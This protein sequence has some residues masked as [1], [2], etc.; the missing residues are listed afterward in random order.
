MWNPISRK[1]QKTSSRSA[2]RRTT[3]Q[4]EALEQRLALSTFLV[5]TAADSGSGSLRQAILDANAAAGAD[6][7]EFNIGGGGAQTISPTSALPNITESVTID[8]WTQPGFAGTPL[9]ELS[10]AVAGPGISG[11]MIAANNSSARGLVINGFGYAGIVITGHDNLVQGNYLGTNAAGTAAMGNGVYGVHIVDASHNRVEGNVISGNGPPGD[12]PG[13][14][15]V[16]VS[17]LQLTG[18][19]Q[20]NTVIGN[21]I[22]T[23]RDGS[24]PIPNV[25]GVFIGGGTRFNT[26]E[27]NLIASNAWYGVALAG[28]VGIHQ[29]TTSSFNVVRGNIIAGNYDGIEVSAGPGK[30]FD[31]STF[32]EPTLGTTLNRIEDNDISGNRNH[33]VIIDGIRADNN[34]VYGNSITGNAG[35]GVAIT[36]GAQGNTIGGVGAAANVIAG[37]GGAGVMVRD[38]GTDF[39]SGADFFIANNL[40][41]TPSTGQVSIIHALNNQ[42]RSNSIHDNGGLGID[43]NMLATDPHGPNLAGDGATLNEAVDADAGPNDRQN[44]PVIIS[45]TP[46]ATTQVF[47]RFHSKPNTTYT[48]DFYANAAADPSGFGE[49]QRYLGAATVTTDAHGDVHY[50]NVVVPGASAAGEVISATAT[51]PDGNTS[52]FSGNRAP[53]AAA[54]GSYTI[55]EGQGVSLDATAS[56]DPDFDALTYTW[57]VNGDGV[58]GD[59]VGMQPTLSWSQLGTLG[60][61]DGLQAFAVKVKVDDDAGHVVISQAAMLTVINVAPTAGVSGPVAGVPGQP[62]DFTLTATD[63]SSVDQ[64]AGFTY[65]IDWGDD[66]PVQTI[67]QSAGNGA[68]P[69]ATHDWAAPGTYQVKVTAGDKDGGLS[70]EVNHTIVIQSILI[71]DVCCDATALVIGGTAG[72]DRIRIVPLESVGDVQVLING[73]AVGDFAGSSFTSIA[74]YGMTGDDDLELAGSIARHAC[75]DGGAGND[76]LKGGTGDD[77]LLGGD[78]DDLLVGGSGRDLLIGGSGADRLVGNADD[79]I[80]I[81][82]FTAWDDVAAALCAIMDE[83]SRT[84]LGYQERAAHL[85]LGGGLNGNVTLNVDSDQGTVTVFDDNAADVLTGSAGVDWFFANLDG[86]GSAAKDKI[87]DLQASEFADD[88]DFIQA[89]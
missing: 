35:A 54:G 36:G 9:I 18:V 38:L 66:T 49:G 11:L 77:I 20:F 68:G 45:S 25:N 82:G 37:N 84:D 87:T 33:G 75:L 50:F 58:F 86:D 19:T 40:G 44:F 67:P 88:L 2:S 5:T 3:L 39:F 34:V 32:T 59:A 10:G 26:V 65:S 23:S 78:G 53:T 81:S 80:L 55:S 17:V 8:G 47:G 71:G 30:V 21:K 89:P 70:A 76:R 43:L 46:G 27:G 29:A 28:D 64:A 74:V 7:I 42:I 79:D 12:M 63:L 60:I 24:A 14:T 6:T 51:D 52:E 16:G 1:H 57:D 31:G 62:R 56:S 83:W 13:T 15:T 41:Q 61:N 69:A 85:R 4:L 22:G 72:N 48:L 73:Q